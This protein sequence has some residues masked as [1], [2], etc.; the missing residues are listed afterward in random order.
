MFTAYVVLTVLTAAADAFSATL[1]FLRYKPIL[2]S[3]A[4]VGVPASLL[5]LLGALKAAGAAGLL[6]GLAVPAIGTAAAVGLVLFFVLAIA[7]HL[8]AH[9]T[10]FGLAAGFLALAAATLGLGLAT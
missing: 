2:V 5:F 10:M 8:R 9:D 7:T 3:M 1:D 6:V 4:S